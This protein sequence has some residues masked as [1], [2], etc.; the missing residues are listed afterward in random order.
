MNSN[1]QQAD[2]W[3][4]EPGRKWITFEN[5]LDL[6][7]EAVNAALIQRAN[8][9]PGEHVLDIGC[10]TGATARAFA[11]HLAPAG[12]ITALDISEPLLEQARSRAVEGA[13]TSR[14]HLVDAQNE[15]IPDAPFDLVTSRFGVMFFSDPVVAFKN[16]REHLRPGGRMVVAA[17]SNISGNPWFEEPRNGAVDQLGPMD[18]SDPHAPGPLAFQDI[19]RVTG[20]LKDAGF[21]NVVGEETVVTLSHPGPLER[22]ASL[23]SN[24]GPAARVLKKYKGG[25]Q[26][27]EAIKSFVHK[28]FLPFE[29][30]GAVLIPARLNFFLGENAD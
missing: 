3:S 8:P 12:S 29:T 16:I 30:P 10:G 1:Q 18:A 17:W 14:Y 21:Q 7:F 26:D 25:P 23:A 5:E 2:Y 13:V 9:Q 6:V 28:K 11:P 22:V 24:I 20:L 27:I 19:A 4:S 15:T